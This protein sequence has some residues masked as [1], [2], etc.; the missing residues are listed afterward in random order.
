M[1]RP[2]LQRQ[3]AAPTLLKQADNKWYPLV[4]QH[5][6]L[7]RAKPGNIKVPWKVRDW[8]VEFETNVATTPNEHHAPDVNSQAGQWIH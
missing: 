5:D 4:D 3:V 2:S 6:V 7:M 8:P 1:S